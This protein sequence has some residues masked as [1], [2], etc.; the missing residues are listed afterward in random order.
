MT[1]ASAFC[2]NCGSGLDA[3]DQFCQ[4]CGH[5]VQVLDAPAPPPGAFTVGGRFRLEGVLGRGSAGTVY[6]AYDESRGSQVALKSLDPALAS[7]PEFVARFRVEAATLAGLS[8]PNVVGVHDYLEVDSGNYLVMERVEGPSLRQLLTSYGRLA[9]EQACGVLS[10]ALSGLG[11]VHERGLLHGDVKPENVLID[12]AGVSQL[13]DFG[14][15]VPLGSAS[16]GGSAPYMS[17]E[18]I[19]ATPLDQRSDLYSMGI[20]LYE[21]LA[22]QPPFMSDQLPTLL[23]RAI[24]EPPRAIAG[25]AAPMAALLVRCLAKDPAARP[26]SADEFLL[27]LTEAAHNSYGADWIQRAGVAALAGALGVGVA[28]ALESGS[29][30]AAMAASS[31]AGTAETGTGVVSTAAK[32]AKPALSHSSRWLPKTLL[33]NKSAAIAASAVLVTGAVAGGVIA[34]NHSPSRVQLGSSSAI[35]SQVDNGGFE[36]PV[37]PVGSYEL[38]SA[39]S[40]FQ[41]WRV[42]GT[43]NVAVISG[44]YTSHGFMF[45]AQMGQQWLD[46]TGLSNSAV[47]VSQTFATRIGKAY[48]LTFA[49]GNIYDPTSFY[50]KTSTVDVVVNGRL[51]L[52]ATNSS[53]MGTTKQVWKGFSTNFRATSSSTTVAFMNADPS[54]DNSNGLDSVTLDARPTTSA[55]ST[56]TTIPPPTTTLP[57]TTQTTASVAPLLGTAAFAASYPPGAYADGYG[58]VAPNT[59]NQGGAPGP[60]DVVSGITWSNWGAPQATGQGQAVYVTNPNTPISEQPDVAATVVAFDLGSCNGGPP[61][62]EMVTWYFPEYGQTFDPAH[63]INACTGN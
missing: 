2:V 34:L 13:T 19:S 37:V 49:V 15:A 58:E 47:G 38:F 25:L 57:R 41:G 54:N 63:A 48:K 7:L 5:A 44:S 16:S 3:G 11:Y 30:Q 61:A 14:Q 60:L 62:Y 8:H 53:G 10:G 21:S 50:G 46:L 33:A 4:S 26:Q 9:P 40:S 55:P 12:S 42:V 18:A 35:R 23:H 51:I 1:M 43:G 6:L 45:P 32:T 20:V 56:T 17:P 29:A 59:I 27:E 52:A 36:T 31:G 39:G 24:H 28:V 22:G